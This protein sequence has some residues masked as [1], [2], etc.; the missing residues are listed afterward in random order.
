[1]FILYYFEQYQ[2]GHDE[3]VILY[4]TT[5]EALEYMSNTRKRPSNN[6]VFKLFKLGEEIP[7]EESIDVEIISVKLNKHIFKIKG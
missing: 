7:L 6:T 1:M 2:D 4:K 5:S 3:G